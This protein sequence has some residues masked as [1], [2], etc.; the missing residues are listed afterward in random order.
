MAKWTRTESSFYIKSDAKIK[1][2]T[3]LKMVK[4]AENRESGNRVSLIWGMR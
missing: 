1:S 4:L 3:V 2:K